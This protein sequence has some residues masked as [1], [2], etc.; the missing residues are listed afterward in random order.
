M[1]KIHITLGVVVFLLFFL[2]LLVFVF[3]NSQSGPVNVRDSSK[4]DFLI[5]KGQSLS[6]VADNL[7]KEGLIKNKTVFLLFARATGQDKKI[8]AGEYQLS[9]NLSL[10]Q[11][12]QTFLSGPQE[13]WVTFPEGL[14]REEM[15]AKVIEIL[16]IKGDSQVLFWNDFLD[17]SEGAEGQLF[18]DTYLFPKDITAQKVVS[19]LKN[20]FAK[21]LTS[22]MVNS[23]Q[24]D[25]LTKNELITLASIVERETKS[26]AERPIVA[27]ILLNRIDLG[28]PLQADA[29]L[30]YITGNQRCGTKFPPAGG[31]KCDWWSVPTVAEK[32]I[33]SA[34]NTYLNQGLPPAPIA[35]PGEEALKA[36]V[37][38]Q[39]SDYLY[40]IHGSDGKIHYAETLDEHNENIAK[41]LR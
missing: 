26:G 24:D 16:E 7:E 4:H 28:M 9:P 6:R 8:Q 40:Y 39:D 33:K 21:K 15:A 18:P 11:I 5:T 14:R 23:A 20:T 1:K 22:E 38:H 13:L 3:W 37:D 36:T 31:L 25:G 29:T 30:Q 32:Q 17:E 2:P 12:M 41:Y 27:G 19:T 10:S 35:N 34:Y